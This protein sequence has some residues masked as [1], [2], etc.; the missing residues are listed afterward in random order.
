MH[1]CALI[2]SGSSSWI[3]GTRCRC[4]STNPGISVSPR[5]IRTTSVSGPAVARIGFASPTR[6]MTPRASTETASTT[7]SLG[8]CFIVRISPTK[9]CAG[10]DELPAAVAI[11]AAAG[12]VTDGPARVI[13]SRRSAASAAAAQRPNLHACRPCDLLINPNPT[14]ALTL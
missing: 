14:N 5:G 7:R 10:L 8:A 3:V 12:G 4:G 1:G 13:A 6:R 2:A 11:A 9:I